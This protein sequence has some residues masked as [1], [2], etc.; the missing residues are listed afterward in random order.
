ML[1]LLNTEA[2]RESERLIHQHNAVM[3]NRNTNYL[4]I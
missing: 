3:D 4:N 1:K 2:D